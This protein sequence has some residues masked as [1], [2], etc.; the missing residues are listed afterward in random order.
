MIPRLVQML[1]VVVVVR[2]PPQVA[3]TERQ[4]FK[5]VL[6]DDTRVEEGILDDGVTG[7]L[8]FLGE[9]DLR[10]IVLPLVGIIGEGVR[11]RR[12]LFRCDGVSAHTEA[13]VFRQSAGLQGI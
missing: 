2:Q 4:V 6:E 1:V 3:L 7:G 8:L 11:A 5:L 10:E 12:F 9:G 13:G